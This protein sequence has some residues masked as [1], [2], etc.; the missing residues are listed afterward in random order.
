KTPLIIAAQKGLAGATQLFLDLNVDKDAKD[1]SGRTALHHAVE[2]GDEATVRLLVEKGA[3]QD[4]K[5]ND[6]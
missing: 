1:S 3:K 5:D 6:G 2:S 4:M